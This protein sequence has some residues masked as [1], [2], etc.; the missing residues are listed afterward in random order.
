M[1]PKRIIL[2][3]PPGAGKGTQAQRLCE[4]LQVPHLATGNL[5]RS[6][7]ANGTPVGVMARSYMES[8]GLVPDEIVIGVLME[9]I[10]VAKQKSGSAWYVLDGFPRTLRQAEA[11]R[12]ELAARDQK[13][14]RVIL[15][16]TPDGTVRERLEQ[17]RSC[18]DPLCGAVYNL[19]THPPKASGKC[20][21]CGKILEI[22]DD[23]RPETIRARQK[24]YWRETAPLIAYYEKEGV[25]V[26]VDGNGS[27]DEVAK[28]IFDVMPHDSKRSGRIQKNSVRKD[29]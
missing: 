28:E 27:L 9:A 25:L 24:Q 20:D 14:D 17:R 18:P 13:I 19:R 2:L 11:L 7:V 3:G 15:I 6:A 5:L 4:V 26:E 16:N 21:I 22:R 29:G 8:G 12:N 10:E 1:L 23:D